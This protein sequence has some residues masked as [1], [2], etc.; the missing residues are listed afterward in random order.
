MKKTNRIKES[1]EFTNVI[2]TGKFEKNNTYRLYSLEN[3]LG[4]VRIGI[5]VSKK[6][7]NAVVRTTTRRRIRAI[8]D[9]LINY[10]SNSLD[11]VVMIKEPFLNQDYVKNTAELEKVLVKILK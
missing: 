2:K 10:Q 9:Q 7:G 4:Y 6:L 1:R 5:A 8:C 11:I 3:N